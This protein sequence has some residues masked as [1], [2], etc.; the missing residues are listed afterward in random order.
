M[1]NVKR[2]AIQILLLLGMAAPA[3]GAETIQIDPEKRFQTID[4]FGAS[5]AWNVQLLDDWSTAGRTAFADLLFDP[6]HGIGL[7]QWRFSITAGFQ[8]DRVPD[9]T[10]SSESFE[11]APGQYD[12][13]RHP[14]RRW[15]LLAAKE[16]GVKDFVAFSYSGTP[17]MTVNGQVNPDPGPLT[18]NLRPDAVDAYASY[19]ADIIQHFARDV[20][21]EDRIDF[22][23]LSPLNEP[24]WKWDRANQEATR[25]S[26]TDLKRVY[27]S[28][29][30]EL[31]QRKLAT[32]VLGVESGEIRDMYRPAE[33]MTGEFKSLFGD[34]LLQFCGDPQISPVLNHVIGYHAYWSD[35]RHRI[36]ADRAALHQ[37]M[38]R[39]PQWQLWQTEYCRMEWHRDLGMDTALN[40]AEVM[41]ADLAIAGASAWDWWLALS[42]GDYKDGLLYTDWHRKG[43]PESIIVPKMFWAIGHFSRFVRPGMV[44]VDCTAPAGLLATSYVDVA[45]RRVVTVLINLSKQDFSVQVK[46]PK[47]AT[48]G[49]HQQ[50][51]LT[52]DRSEDNLRRLQP[53]ATG[54][55][56]DVP[57]RSLVT[58]VCD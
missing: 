22:Q 8:P 3:I 15:M 31:R 39:F 9:P 16:R 13:S 6:T 14:A 57:A 24:Q 32:R 36:S 53:S 46:L 34:Y 18:T 5:D 12:W 35:D 45:S 33:K 50:V 1:T 29:D 26:N 48:R 19:L 42:R 4:H 47:S 44:R 17:R 30:A 10:R 27:R 52:G 56:V 37:A 23:W 7:S 25:A 38:A 11:T 41:H 20:P 55:P 2:I 58:I 54:D 28:V 43:D 49:R 21:A 40:V 51:Y